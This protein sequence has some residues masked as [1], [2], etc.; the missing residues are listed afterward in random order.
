MA[1]YEPESLPDEYQAVLPPTYD[2]TKVAQAINAAPP[3]AHWTG[4]A[5]F[6][7]AIV[8]VVLIIAF[9]IIRL[10]F[11]SN[12]HCNNNNNCTNGGP[13]TIQNS[14]V[15]SATVTGFNGLL[16]RNS[17]SGTGSVP[18]VVTPPSTAIGQAF[19]VD[20]TG[21][22]TTVNVSVSGQ[23]VAPFAVVSGR[24]TEFIWLNQTT[25]ASYPFA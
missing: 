6:V 16:W 19:I 7:I 21:G 24:S 3:K 22:S 9:I 15:S 10:V 1:Y 12:H 13:W 14:S 11:T 4:S 8:A 17:F 20:N 18:L 2:S 23:T 25:L 5:G